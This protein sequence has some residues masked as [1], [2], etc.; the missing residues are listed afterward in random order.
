MQISTRILKTLRA[1]LCLSAGDFI[2]HE[3]SIFDIFKS[4][5]ASLPVSLSKEESLVTLYAH[6]FVGRVMLKAGEEPIALKLSRQ[7]TSIGFLLR[8][9]ESWILTHQSSP[10]DKTTF[11][12]EPTSLG[13]SFT[14]EKD[15]INFNT[16]VLRLCLEMAGLAEPF[17]MAHFHA[18]IV[19]V[20]G[21]VPEFQPELSAERLKRFFALLEQPLGKLDELKELVARSG[22]DEA[23]LEKLMEW[24][25]IRFLL[26]C[27]ST[28]RAERKR[29]LKYLFLALSVV[30]Q[31]GRA[32]LLQLTSRLLIKNPFFISD[33]RAQNVRS[34]RQAIQINELFPEPTPALVLLASP[35][36]VTDSLQF[37]YLTR[38]EIVEASVEDFGQVGDVYCFGPDFSAGP[39][40]R[41]LC[42]PGISPRISV[43]PAFADPEPETE[44][45]QRDTNDES[46]NESMVSVGVGSECKT[47][48][49]RPSTILEV[50]FDKLMQSPAAYKLDGL[51]GF[52]YNP[53]RVAE[54]LNSIVNLLAKAVKRRNVDCIVVENALQLFTFGESTYR[55]T[56]FRQLK[57]QLSSGSRST[58]FA[59]LIGSSPAFHLLSVALFKF[60]MRND[61]AVTLKG[62][63][64]AFKLGF[65]LFLDDLGSGHSRPDDAGFNGYLASEFFRRTQQ[66]SVPA[67]VFARLFLHSNLH[68]RYLERCFLKFVQSSLP[69]SLAL[70]GGDAPEVPTSK[71]F[72]G[73]VP[74]QV[75]SDPYNFCFAGLF[76]EQDQ[77]ELKILNRQDHPVSVQLD[78]KMFGRLLKASGKDWHKDQFT[79]LSC[80]SATRLFYTF[81]FVNNA[82]NFEVKP[83][84][85]CFVVE[86]LSRLSDKET[87]EDFVNRFTTGESQNLQ[88]Y[89]LERF[90]YE[91]K[92]GG[93]PD[94]T[95][96]LR[97]LDATQPE[98]LQRLELSPQIRENK[99]KL[100]RLRALMTEIAVQADFEGIKAHLSKLGLPPVAVLTPEYG[101]F[102]K[103]GGL[104]VMIEDLTRELA[105]LGETIW[106]FMPYF[107]NEVQRKIYETKGFVYLRNI[108]VGCRGGE[109]QVGVHLLERSNL[110]FFL[111]HNAGLWRDIYVQDNKMHQ[112]KQLTVFNRAALQ[113]MVEQGLKPSVVL[114]NDWFAGCA[115]AYKK[116]RFFGDFFDSVNFFHIVHNLG[117]DYQGR[118]YLDHNESPQFYADEVEL[119][120]DFLFDRN[121]TGKI[122]NPTR[123]A[124][125]CSDQWGTVSKSYRRE[126]IES[127]DLRYALLP[128]TRPFA[129]PNGIRAVDLADKLAALPPH[130]EQKAALLL[131]YFGL[132]IGS[133]HLD[134]N[135]LFGYVGRISVQKGVML[136]LDTIEETLMR[137]NYRAFWIIGGMVDGSEYAQNCAN[138][139]LALK[140]RFPK[141]VWGDPYAFFK[142][143]LAL[144]RGADFVLMPS[145]F[146]PGGIVQHE[147]FFAGTP[148]IAFMTGG[149]RDTVH[150]FNK[151]TLEG[152]GFTFQK[153]NAPDFQRAIHRALNI[154]LEKELN[155]RL[156]QNASVSFINVDKVAR[157]WL[158]EFY[159]LSGKVF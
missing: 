103:K 6:Y 63:P 27:T 22:D 25:E 143:G 47:D 24:V 80:S 110:K 12:S 95:E 108:G 28:Y 148:V 128:Y 133:E 126:I 96:L 104:A 13:F 139:L 30:S 137:S 44:Q 67:R 31:E 76:Y 78:L 74:V 48:T 73:F 43:I 89:L 145:L 40:V 38:G 20:G 21:L 84:L 120:L 150:E 111:F 141:N 32:G 83:G 61:L 46:L 60:S 33:P 7:K 119:Q 144:N 158:A 127:S 124:L 2:H 100:R 8:R 146:E 4:Y 134:D 138:K 142:D 11:D 140:A 135:V 65:C 81:E 123:C 59:R 56:S 45:R 116:M 157:A 34:V 19:R 97:K 107:D 36:G 101:E 98:G 153:Y 5:L 106:V 155:I 10:T 18:E 91:D 154:F 17:L 50:N 15:K 93:K 147:S 58:D 85:S 86:T 125:I 109:I 23:A 113:L 121:W 118:I 9:F 90:F 71:G 82:V 37:R 114:T 77:V 105:S 117:G 52:M 51:R 42:V 57:Q 75:R 53:V 94:V 54:L 79:R 102:V 112:L 39:S 87:P 88:L 14:Q 35:K 69:V 49:E 41:L 64:Q 149:L 29:V 1:S 16:K 66:L 136:I 92:K 55:P 156:R 130:N 99:F 129:Y 3:D 26:L 115:A 122:L 152:N 132:E 68:K 72:A 62:E 151:T 70:D 131:K 159:R